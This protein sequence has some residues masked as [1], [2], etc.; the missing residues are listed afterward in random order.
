VNDDWPFDGRSSADD[1]LRG[2]NL[3]GKTVIVTG[4]NTGIGFETARAL[5]A[6][7]ADV[8]LACRSHASGAAAVAGIMARHPAASARFAPLDLA[9]LANV[10][11]FCDQ[12]ADSRI[13]ALICNAGSVSTTY[14]E[15]AD[16]FERTVGVCHI[17]HFLLV[18]RLLPRLLAA[19]QPRVVMVSSESHRH[20]KRLDFARLPLRA[21]NYSTMVAYGQAKLCNAL[22]ARELQR[23][24]GAQGLMACSLHPGTLVT[25]EIGRESALMR[26]LMKLV[27]PFTK[28]ANQGAAT[29]VFAVVH[30]PASAIAGLYLADCHPRST[31][32]EV[33]NVDVARRLWALSEQWVAAGAVAEGAD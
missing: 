17:G 5:A 28:N 12:L 30:E 15:T 10:R 6:A 1:V 27:S 4:A 8:V 23:R 25:T 18:Q 14:L 13:D 29:S 9:S 7:G 32:P 11:A 2:R 24:Y 22:M 33:E 19:G 21:D 26:A 20:P 3:A 31:T 16:G